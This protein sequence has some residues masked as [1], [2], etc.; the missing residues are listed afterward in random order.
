MV[1][2]GIRNPQVYTGMDEG[3]KQLFNPPDLIGI[4]IF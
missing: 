2:W 1:R 4:L 3:S